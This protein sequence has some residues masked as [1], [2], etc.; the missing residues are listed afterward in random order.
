MEAQPN[1][2]SIYLKTL[3]NRETGPSMGTNPY[4]LSLPLHD[5]V[6]R[7][8]KQFNSLEIKRIHAKNLILQREEK[9]GAVLFQ[10]AKLKECY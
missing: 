2:T 3:T 4:C 5:A 1:L 6:S 7:F 9:I 10:L 8:L